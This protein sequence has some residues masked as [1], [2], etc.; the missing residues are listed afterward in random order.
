MHILIIPSWFKNSYNPLEGIFFE[1]QAK[2]IQSI[3]KSKIGFV[4]CHILSTSS[5]VRKIHKFRAFFS[6]KILFE[7]NTVPIIRSELYFIPL[8]PKNYLFGLDKYLNIGFSRHVNYVIR[9]INA[10]RLRKRY[11]SLLDTYVDAFGKPGLL[12]IQSAKVAGKIG[13]HFSRILK[14]P[15]IIT[16]HWSNLATPELK[17]L[18]NNLGTIYQLSNQNYAVSLG[19][20]KSLSSLSGSDFKLLPNFI[21]TDFFKPG[22][23]K[24]R[25]KIVISSI[26]N[27]VEIKNFGLLISAFATLARNRNSIELHI[28]GEGHEREKLE[29]LALELDIA[30]D[31]YFWGR[32]DR[33]Q[34][35]DLIR[36]S[37]IFVLPSIRETFGVVLIE[38]LS[39]GVPIVAV[40]SWG[41]ETIITSDH[42]GYLCKNSVDSMS[43]AI[44]KML[45]NIST[46]KKEDLRKHIIDHYSKNALAI[47]MLSEY[48]QHTKQTIFKYDVFEEDH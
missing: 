39:C 19:F 38:S 30:E 37:S 48:K 3:D 17:S 22:E 41:P 8:L 28:G 46:F 5:P 33:D 32:L 23:C 45:D 20:C 2:L 36:Q 40:R 16:E 12:H 18:P 42:L 13:L 10:H 7:L 25:R 21:D 27:L 15:Y 6:H 44:E 1:E 47:K 11:D 34:V 4:Y 14:V 43:L 9:R 24:N 31:V 26:G 35:R 29:A